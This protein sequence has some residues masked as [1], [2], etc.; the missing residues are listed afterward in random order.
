[1]N[2]YTIR[3]SSYA[4]AIKLLGN[5]NRWLRQRE[6]W[7]IVWLT[8]DWQTQSQNS[9]TS[10]TTTASIQI[11]IRITNCHGNGKLF[12]FAGDMRKMLIKFQKIGASEKEKIRYSGMEA[13][14]NLLMSEINAFELMA[15][16]N[17]SSASAY[18]ATTKSTATTT[19]TTASTAFVYYA[20]H[21]LLF[22][23]LLLRRV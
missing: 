2:I 23:F 6:N 10:R 7:S 11:R 5:N 12:A 9:K 19:T 13:A 22:L 14:S 17:N 20:A 8:F 18:G 4:L 16:S 15:K 3:C 21:S 1:M